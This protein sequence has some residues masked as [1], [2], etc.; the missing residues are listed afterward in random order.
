MRFD[1]SIVTV[2][3]SSI[4]S[5]IVSCPVVLSELVLLLLNCSFKISA[6]PL[7]LSHNVPLYFSGVTPT[8]S[9]FLCL[10][11]DPSFLLPLFGSS[12]VSGRMLVST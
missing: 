12:D 6:L 7:G 1:T 2:K 8:E 4:V 3:Q 9:V 11:K 5:Q 10:M